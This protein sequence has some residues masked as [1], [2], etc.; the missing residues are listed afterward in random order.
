MTRKEFY[1]R[2]PEFQPHPTTA[3]PGLDVFRDTYLRLAEEGATEVLSIHI[4]QKLRSILTIAHLAAETTEVIPVKVLDS[5]QLTL[6]MGFLAE[7][8]ARMAKD[9][10]PLEDIL[11]VLED[12]ISR[13]HVFAALD[14]VEFLRRSGRMNFA[15]ASFASLLHVKPLLKMYDGNPTSERVRT[16]GKAMRRLVDLLE[17]AAPLERVALVHIHTPEK[18]EELRQHA[19]HLLPEGE[20][21]SVDI[22]P[23][24]GA[25]LG[26]SA[27]GFACISRK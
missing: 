8:A 18:A 27:V 23:V 9:G 1:S 12:Q 4:S 15:M 21:L 10:A 16:S 20:T 14:T 7:T 11:G 26:P 25:H 3:D 19:A 2:L 24:I 6:G 5:R 22:T 13:T 17:Q